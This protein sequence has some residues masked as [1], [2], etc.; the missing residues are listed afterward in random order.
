MAAASNAAATRWQAAL[1]VAAGEHHAPTDADRRFP[2]MQA[3]KAELDERKQFED[4]IRR[5]YFHVKPLDQGQLGAWNN[6]IDYILKKEDAGAIVRL[7]ER[8]LVP[9]ASYPGTSSACIRYSTVMLKCNS[10]LQ[11]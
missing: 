10:F 9:C 5:P 11:Y 8:C 7:F 1:P 3:T 2:A 4:L 6:Y